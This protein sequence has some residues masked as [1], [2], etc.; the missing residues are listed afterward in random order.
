MATLDVNC[1]DGV[2]FLPRL[3]IGQRCKTG[4]F[5]YWIWNPG[6]HGLE[7]HFKTKDRQAAITAWRQNPGAVL[8]M[9]LAAS[10]RCVGLAI[11]DGSGVIALPE[12][13]LF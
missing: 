8:R 9:Q 11:N 3:F 4:R 6:P 5:E 12:E 10:D 1:C 2:G 13:E 7:C